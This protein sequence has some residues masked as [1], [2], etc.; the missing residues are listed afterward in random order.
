[1][2]GTI[3]LYKEMLQEEIE[4]RKKAEEEIQKWQRHSGVLK[5]ECESLQK[6]VEECDAG[7][8]ELA[9][10][11]DAVTA[12]LAVTCGKPEEDG[13]FT[14]QIPVDEIKESFNRVVSVD[15]KD[16]FYEIRV[17]RREKKDEGA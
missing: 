5:K 15:A 9:M 12:A 2:R 6:R 8:T 10:L 16:G 13:S 4:K 3:R 14:L 7:S 17:K 11:V 1:M